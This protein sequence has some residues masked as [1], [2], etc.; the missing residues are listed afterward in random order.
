MT[1][2]IERAAR[3]SGGSELDSEHECALMLDIVKIELDRLSGSSVSLRV[4]PLRND[5]VA[6]FRRLNGSW[7]PIL[8]NRSDYSVIDGHYRI[9]AAQQLG[10]SEITAQLFEGSSDAA[11]LEALRRNTAKGLSLTLRE[12]EK[13][14][15]FVLSSHSYWSDR[16]IA[17]LCSLSPST[18]GRLRSE[19]SCPGVQ[20]SQLDKREGRDDRHRPVDKVGVRNRI[21]NA[22]RASPGASLRA[23]AQQVGC[24]PE[25]VRAAR[26]RLHSEEQS[27]S[28]CGAVL[29]CLEVSPANLGNEAD[30]AIMSMD[31]GVAFAEWFAHSDVKEED[32]RRYLTKVPLSR[33]YQIAD[34]ARRRAS[35]WTA[36]ARDLE[37]RTNVR[38]E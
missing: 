34:E 35:I 25:T 18:I 20:I 29:K 21:Q 38:S 14:A 10:H 24:S 16:R 27:G 19:T 23:I 17:E 37:A 36:F 15:S 2:D 3:Q 26:A 9:V 28:S 11:Y 1:I 31:E 22:L 8:V 4:G 32:S 6:V 12:R 7:P 30:L 13:A 33:I 5:H